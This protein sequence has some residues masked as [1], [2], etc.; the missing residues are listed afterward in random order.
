MYSFTVETAIIRD[1]DLSEA[2]KSIQG[3]FY[4]ATIEI[5]IFR[6]AIDNHRWGQR[7]SLTI[8]KD[9]KYFLM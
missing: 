8:L 7:I 9:Y 2:S 4:W 5:S 3:V 6:N 1:R